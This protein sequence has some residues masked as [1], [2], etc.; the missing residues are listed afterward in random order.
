MKIDCTF[1]SIRGD[2]VY[3][4]VNEGLL[5][6]KKYIFLVRRSSKAES[7]T[8]GSAGHFWEI[9]NGPVGAAPL[10]LDIFQ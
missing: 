9:A 5:P 6:E 2:S 1:G 10:L 4:V 8:A 3:L 7:M